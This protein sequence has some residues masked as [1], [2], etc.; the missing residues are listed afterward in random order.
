[1][2]KNKQNLYTILLILTC[3]VAS[4]LIFRKIWQT[5]DVAKKK[6]DVPPP[7][8]SSTVQAGEAT[9]NAVT[10]EQPAT[11]GTAD[12]GVQPTP[13]QPAEV[14]STFAT[15]GLDYFNDALFIG[16]SR[17]VGIQDY[18]TFTNSDFFCTEGLSSANIENETINGQTFNQLIDSKQYGKI[19]VMLGINEVGNDF[20]F[21]LT[22]YRAVIEKLK[23]HQSNAI[24]YVQANLHVSSYAETTTIN[25]EGINYLNSLIAGLADNK[26]VFYIDI[27]EVYDDANGCLTDGYT[28]DGVHP[29]AQYYK[30]WC[31]WLCTKTIAAGGATPEAT[32]DPNYYTAT[33]VP[34]A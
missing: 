25:N 29:L 8:I 1:M 6:V 17:T 9:T 21:T 27:N 24:I 26:K 15:S 31:D 32:V 3:L 20:Q 23:A 5:S 16:D 22:K 2:N 28:S 19:Y 12:N 30:T 18:G 33:D 11:E 34:V 4:P 13:D 7:S 14:V 10:P